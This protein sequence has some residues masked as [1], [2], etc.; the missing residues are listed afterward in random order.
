MRALVAVASRHGSTW[1]IGSALAS[2]FQA[3]GISADLLEA[4]DVQSL[5]EYDLV[6]IGSAVYMGHWMVDALDIVDRFRAQLAPMPVWLFS[7]GPIGADDP[8]PQGD[9]QDIASVAVAVDAWGHRVFAG[10][11]DKGVLGL[12]ER[13][14]TGIVRAP[15]GDF[16][17]WDAIRAWAGEIAT[18][19]T[20]GVR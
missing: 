1:E 16:R 3:N 10:K 12:G 14:A 5:D 11:L 9:P 17:D 4:R 19:M 7:S 2:E 15:E 13:L 8:K 18:A 20:V 6:V